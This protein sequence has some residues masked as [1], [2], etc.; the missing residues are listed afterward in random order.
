MADK[1]AKLLSKIPIKDLL[2]IQEALKK[3]KSLQLEGLNIK[4]IKGQKDIFR[5]RIGSYRIVFKINDKNI[6]LLK[7]DKRNEKTYRG[8]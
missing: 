8:F 7:I 4:A 1:I 3:I 5:V 2:R 6:R